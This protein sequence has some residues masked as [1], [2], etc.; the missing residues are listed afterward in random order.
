[1]LIFF[2]FR[3]IAMACKKDETLKEKQ[4]TTK[5]DLYNAKTIKE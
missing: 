2:T 3:K 1:M 4:K 5:C